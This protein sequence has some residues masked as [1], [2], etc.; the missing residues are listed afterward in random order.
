MVHES[1]HALGLSDFAIRFDLYPVSHPT[2]PD[3]VMSYDS[4]TR[5][6]EPD[7]S[8]YPLDLMAIHTLYQAVGP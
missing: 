3:A 4:K 8:P 6:D 5:V 2:V 1:G 7:C